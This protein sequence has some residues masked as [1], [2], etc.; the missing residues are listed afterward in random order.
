MADLDAILRRYEQA[1]NRR[2]N[3]ESTWQEIADRV[4]PSMANFTSMRSDG[5][6]RTEMMFDSTASLALMKFS[7]ALESFSFP[8]N[9]IWHDLTV[10]DP[11]LKKAVTVKRYLEDVRD[12]LFSVRY[13]PRANFQG[14]ANE[15]LTSYGCFGTGSMFIDDDVRSRVVRYKSMPLSHTYVLENEHGWID[16]VFRKIPRSARQL[17]EQFGNDKLPD[18]VRAK[19]EKDPDDPCFE[20]IHYVGPRTDYD[21]SKVGYL[22]MPWRSCY[23]MA[24]PK[25]ELSEGGFNSWPFGFG[26]FLTSSG[27]VYGRSPAWLALSNIKVL[28][29]QKKTVLKAG[30]MVT[31]P[32]LLAAEDGVLSQFSMQPGYMNFGALNDRGEPLVK[33]LITQARVDIGLDMMDKEREIIA[34]GFLLDVFQVLV[35][36]QNMTATQALE[37]MNERANIIAPLIGRL[38]GELLGAIIEREV[39]ILADA[40]QLPEMPPE[41][42]EAQGEYRIEFTGPMNRAMRAGEG[43]AIVRTLEAAIPLAQIDPG[44]LDA[45]KVPESVAELAEI[46]GMPARLRRSEDEI[47]AMKSGRAEQSQA[48]ALLQA[49]PVVSQT[50]AN[51][52]KMQQNGGMPVV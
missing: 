29:T 36:N 22:G 23:V 20:L 5:D 44:A 41:L 37:L 2:S 49:A 34:S 30:H 45:I 10:D 52:L 17:V 24:D 38:Q 31:T 15:V 14:Q 42:I 18:K 47:K 26:R 27:E 1:K 4:W 19:L 33:P 35:E 6:K 46:N 40:G 48:D 39:Q 3:W 7:A 32:P 9:A 51:L 25:V 21:T 16:T 13:S 28:N 43:A 12:R 11:E 50:A 8:R